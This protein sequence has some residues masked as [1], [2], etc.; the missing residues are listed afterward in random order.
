MKID[1]GPRRDK[2]SPIEFIII[3]KIPK[4][5][6]AFSTSLYGSKMTAFELFTLDKTPKT[7][8]PIRKK[9]IKLPTK[10]RTVGK[11]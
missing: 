8:P 11:P 10:I 3:P 5:L 9:K 6:P 1:H 4:M 7:N 2:N